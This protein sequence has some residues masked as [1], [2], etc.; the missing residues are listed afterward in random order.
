MKVLKAGQICKPNNMF[1]IVSKE[2][3]N[4]YLQFTKLR[5][6]AHVTPPLKFVVI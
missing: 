4:F 2:A 6:V 3:I 5:D 1:M